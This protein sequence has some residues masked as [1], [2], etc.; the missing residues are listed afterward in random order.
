MIIFFFFNDTATTEIYTYG[1]TLSL[2]DA[3]PIS[4]FWAKDVSVASPTPRHRGNCR[5]CAPSSAGSRKRG[6]R[7]R[8]CST[9]FAAP[10][11]RGGCR[12]TQPRQT[13]KKSP[14]S[15]AMN[16]LLQGQR[17]AILPCRDTL[18]CL[19]GSHSLRGSEG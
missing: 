15:T 12:H 18:T 19:A 6:W 17:P 4:P 5:R 10:A 7:R 1:H 16:T 9:G 2:H 8:A 14:M 11:W 3:L 13:P